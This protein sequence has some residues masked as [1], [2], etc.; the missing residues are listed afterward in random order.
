MA[1]D[2]YWNSVVLAMHLNDVALADLKGRSPS[3]S[4]AVQ[5]KIW[6]RTNKE[7]TGGN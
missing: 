4:G 2:P 6:I 3:I 1:G 7:T 5:M